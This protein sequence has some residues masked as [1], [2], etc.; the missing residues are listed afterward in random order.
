MTPSNT[1]TPAA[2]AAGS[3]PTRTPEKELAHKIYRAWMNDE[4]WEKCVTQ[5]M[6][7]P[8]AFFWADIAAAAAYTAPAAGD[9]A[10]MAAEEILE[11]VNTLL[12]GHDIFSSSHIQSWASIIDRHCPA[13]AGGGEALKERARQIIADEE[14]LSAADD[15]NDTRLYSMRL[16]RVYT[17]QQILGEKPLTTNHQ[18]D[19]GGKV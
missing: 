14:R 6:A 18:P 4:R 12:P 8:N 19:S 11:I 3:T 15:K 17:A 10:R 1:R 9:G 13:T 7:Y 16:L 2:G 5:G